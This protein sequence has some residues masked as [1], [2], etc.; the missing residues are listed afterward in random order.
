MGSD[1]NCWWQTARVSHRAS[2]TPSSAGGWEEAQWGC[3]ALSGL[4]CS[5]V[6]VLAILMQAIRQRCMLLGFAVL[7]SHPRA[8]QEVKL[9]EGLALPVSCLL[10][11]QPSALLC[12]LLL[13]D[14]GCPPMEKT[15]TSAGPLW[16]W[17]Q[18]GHATTK[19][20]GAPSS[21]HPCLPLSLPLLTPPL[22]AGQHAGWGH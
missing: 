3:A 22:V 6:V 20:A 16:A 21:A 4:L 1:S 7:V 13:E 11:H 18:P 12:R 9:Q 17:D 10:P 5:E 8:E 14:D 19:P 15:Q 2:S